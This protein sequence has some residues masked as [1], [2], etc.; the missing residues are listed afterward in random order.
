MTSTE[1]T[2]TWEY[3]TDSVAT[4]TEMAKAEVKPAD[5]GTDSKIPLYIGA[6][7]SFGG[8]WDCSGIIVAAQM[9][10]DHINE[11]DDI[12]PEYKLRMIYNDTQVRSGKVP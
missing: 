7:F 6:Y 5:D 12:L 2:F 4:S 3:A 8:G 10:L 9:A 11:R 1:T